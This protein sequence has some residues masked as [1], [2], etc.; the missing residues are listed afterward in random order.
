MIYR[1]EFV[2]AFFKEDMPAF[3]VSV[4]AEKVKEDDG[5]KEFLVFIRKVEVV[6]FGVIFNILLERTRAVWTILAERRERDKVETETF[7]DDICGNFTLCKRVTGKIP[8]RLLAARRFID[9]WIG[10]ILIMNVNKERVIGAKHKL[11]LDFKVAVCKYVL[12]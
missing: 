11:A 1:E 12:K 7:T 5:L 10:C 2:R 4:I 3:T 6:I 9:G 8:E